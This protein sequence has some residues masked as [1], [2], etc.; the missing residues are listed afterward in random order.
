[1]NESHTNVPSAKPTAAERP[2][3]VAVFKSIPVA[4]RAIERLLTAGFTKQ[5]INVLCS[6]E[7]VERHFKEFEHQDPA[8]TH[9]AGTTLVG[10][11]IGAVLGGLSVV[12][13]AVA[14]GGVALLATAPIAMWGG[15]AAGGLI[16]AMMSRG[17]ER[18]LANFYDQAV[19]KGNIL[20]AIDLH[21][22][23]QASRLSEAARILA[24]EGAEPMS[25]PEG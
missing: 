14:T 12:A 5:Q 4:D 2:I 7:A 3:R 9:T 22:S 15:G 24:E 21:E 13:G 25:L 6:N 19:A 20:V 10:G 8:G 11:T 23:P 17:V 16:G 1:M 18:E